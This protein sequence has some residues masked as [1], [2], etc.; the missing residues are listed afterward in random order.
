M[1]AVKMIEIKLEV[2]YVRPIHQFLTIFLQFRSS[3]IWKSYMNNHVHR[4]LLEN[5]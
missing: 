5:T 3:F 2:I 4:A 1:E